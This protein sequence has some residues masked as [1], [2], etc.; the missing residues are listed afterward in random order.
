[1]IMHDFRDTGRGFEEEVR[2]I[3]RLLWPTPFYQGAALVEGRERDGLIETDDAIHVVEATTLRTKAKAQEDIDKTSKLVSRLRREHPDKTIK[4]WFI[5]RDDLTADQNAVAAQYR[6]TV[7]S[8]PYKEFLSR[9]VDARSYLT[10]RE[11]RPFGSVADP[12]TNNPHVTRDTYVEPSLFNALSSESCSFDDFTATACRQGARTVL[13]GDFGAGKSMALREAFFRVSQAFY[14]GDSQRFPVYLNLRSHIGQSSPVEALIREANN[15]GYG[16]Y[17]DLVKA[18]RADLLVLFL[19]GFDELVTPAW[20]QKATQLREHRAACTKLVA[21]FM[22]ESPSDTPIVVSGRFSYF[23]TAYEMERALRLPSIY[24]SFRLNDFSKLQAAEFLKKLNISSVLP[25]WLPARP[26]LLAY[27][28]AFAKSSAI[29]MRVADVEPAE[30]W[31]YL[32]GRVCE[33]E[34][35]IHTGLYPEYVRRLLERIAT[36]ARYSNDIT[37]PISQRDIA[38]AFR[39]IFDREPDDNN[40]GMLLRLPGLIAAETVGDERRFI[41][42][43]FATACAAGDLYEFALAPAAFPSETFENCRSNIEPLGADF[44][45]AKLERSGKPVSTIHSVL[46]QAGQSLACLK[47]DLI[48]ALASSNAAARDKWTVIDG[49]SIDH[50]DLR[51][52]PAYFSKI[53]LVECTVNVLEVDLANTEGVPQFELSM[54]GV[55]KGPASGDALT[56]WLIGTTVERYESEQ[57][58]NDAILDLSIPPGLKVGLTALRKVYLQRGGGRQENGL[59]RGLKPELRACVPEVLRRMVSLDYL[60]I[61]NRAGERIYVKNPEKITEVHQILA[62]RSAATG[63]LV[64]ELKSLV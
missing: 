36:K 51:P 5:A 63:R 22:R 35:D 9:L 60:A 29:D 37:S 55:L 17:D 16:R 6:R 30:G 38:K 43:D 19:D 50:L 2:R 53:K 56:S 59:Y 1:M 49:A 62:R 47:G 54:I 41:D 8:L 39:E 61:S 28:A 18:W 20:T 12:V 10:F 31:D 27:L 21:E 34:V 42:S 52:A 45:V 64:D 24:N 26:L 11:K 48:I 23:G 58:T 32:I 33:R 46:E 3:A 7:T 25:D 15:T 13:L 4:G 57:L 44:V 40:L 14:R